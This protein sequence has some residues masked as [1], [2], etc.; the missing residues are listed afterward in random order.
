V[1]PCTGIATVFAFCASLNECSVST[2][3][4]AAKI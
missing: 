4:P 1:N 3:P 2:H